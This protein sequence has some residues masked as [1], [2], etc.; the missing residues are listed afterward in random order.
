MI[1]ETEILFNKY[2][3]LQ[4]VSKRKT[5]YLYKPWID[6]GLQQ[7][8]RKQNILFTRK[9]KLSSD[10]NITNFK[11]QKNKVTAA[12][13]RKRA[14]Y[15]RDYFKKHKH[16]SCKMWEG[17][18]MALGQNKRNKSMPDCILDKKGKKLESTKDKVN[19]FAKHF[20][21]VPNVTRN[22]I[23]PSQK[24]FKEYLAKI[25]VCNNY[26]AL[27]NTYPDD[28]YKLLLQLKNKSSSGPLQISNLFLK[29]IAH[30][31]AAPLSVSI[32]KSMAAG[33]V[34]NILKIGKQTPVFKSGEH[35]VNN[36]RPITVCNAFSKILEKVVRDRL[37]NFLESNK[38]INKFQFGFRPGHSTTHAIINLF[39]ATLDGLDTKLKVGGVYLDISKAFDTIPH[40]ILITKLEHYGIRANAL[41]WFESYLKDREQYVEVN[42]CKSDK[43]KTNISVP[44]GG[45]L[46][47]ILFI[48]FTNDISKATNKLK[49]SIY[50]DDTCLI[51]AI[52]R[53]DYSL[54]AKNEINIIMDWFRANFLLLNILKT[55]YTHFGPHYPKVYEKG[56]E[57]LYDLHRVAP[58][59]LYDFIDVDYLLT[60]TGPPPETINKIGYFQL[61]DLHDVAPSLFFEEYIECENGVSII[62]SDNVK[63]LGMYI[64][65]NL[66]FRYHIS[67]LTC[68]ISRMVNTFWK[69][70][71]I[72][73]NTK[74]TIYHS[75]I[76]SHI[77]YGII[78]WCSEYAK[79]LL[80]DADY[81]RIP[82][83]FKSVITAQNKVVRAIFRKP[84][85]DR[86]QKQYTRTSPLYSQLDVLRIQELYYY[87]L[88][89]LVHDYFYKQT[90]PEILRDQFDSFRIEKPQVTRSMNLN[91]NYNKPNYIKTYRKPTIAGSMFWNSLPNDL[92]CIKS[93]NT[94]KNKL[95][96]FLIA[97]YNS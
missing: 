64:D 39:E 36:F 84:K 61:Q 58:R 5:K 27:H 44:Q 34:P 19:S 14:A 32:N 49:L 25:P 75:L 53:E 33:Y 3:P 50:A 17:I 48:L 18:N 7:E 87:N 21:S 63:Y 47:A 68:K 77:N 13:R 8:L 79:N 16:D 52:N 86:N 6:R 85:Y 23:I 60:Y 38:I 42:K 74:K 9:N 57:D 22:K 93:K 91:L 82:D 28:I 72:D 88:G 67:I 96:R 30:K 43:Y 92:K 24:N 90:F 2:A 15:F 95:K 40:D 55:D 35:C 1:D 29:K 62:A 26:L 10:E 71:D 46:S 37:S 76:E 51:I 83:C 81:N 4:E 56:E 66:N 69:C 20:E 70:T 11:I 65:T 89:I 41:M 12:M 59:F 31:L 78:I 54:I 73:F 45:V 97:K 80:T 94:F